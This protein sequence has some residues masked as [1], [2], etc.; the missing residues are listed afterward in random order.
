MAHPIMLRYISYS[1]TLAEHVVHGLRRCPAF[2][3]AGTC[4]FSPVQLDDQSVS[5]PP[6]GW[7]HDHGPTNVEAMVKGSTPWPMG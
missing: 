6:T 5:D 1:K 3:W 2:V 7:P 4:L